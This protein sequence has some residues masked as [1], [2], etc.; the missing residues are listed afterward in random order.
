VGWSLVAK[1]AADGMRE[2]H[3]PGEH[4]AQVFVVED[5]ILMTFPVFSSVKWET[6]V[7]SAFP[8]PVEGVT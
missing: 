4:A 1:P 7:D 8:L 3:P 6:M 5:T 2:F